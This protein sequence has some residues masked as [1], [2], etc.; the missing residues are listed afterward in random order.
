MRWLAYPRWLYGGIGLHSG[1]KIRTL[2]GSR[3]DS[4]YSYHIKTDC[5]M[6]QLG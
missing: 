2:M 4:E 3:F 1:L 6:E 5:G